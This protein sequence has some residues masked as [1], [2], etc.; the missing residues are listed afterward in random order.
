MSQASY[1][2]FT[3]PDGRLEVGGRSKLKR[4]VDSI[5]LW[6]AEVKLSLR[7]FKGLRF[8]S[9]VLLFLLVII[10]A[11][12]S[13]RI[14]CQEDFSCTCINI[15]DRTDM[16][17]TIT[18]PGFALW[19][20]CF[21]GANVTV[22]PTPTCTPNPNPPRPDDSVVQNGGFECGLAPWIAEDVTNTKHAITSPGDG[23]NFAYQF[24]QIGPVDPA[25]DMHPAAVSQDLRLAANV[26]YRLK[27]R[28]FF[29][30]CTQ[31]E[32][33][34]G[35]MINSQP[36]YTVDA[37][38][39]GAG[40]FTD[41]T[42]EFT[43]PADQTNLRFE[44]LTHENLATVKIDNVE[45]LQNLKL[46][47]FNYFQRV[48]V[49]KHFYSLTLAAEFRCPLDFKA[50]H[51]QLDDLPVGSGGRVYPALEIMYS[52]SVTLWLLLALSLSCIHVDAAREDRTTHPFLS[53]RH[54][55]VL[56]MP[57]YKYPISTSAAHQSLWIPGTMHDPARA[58]ADSIRIM[59]PSPPQI[60]S[61]QSV[62]HPAKKAMAC[63]T[64]QVRI[65]YWAPRTAAPNASYTAGNVS[66]PLVKRGLATVVEDGFTF[67][68]PSVYIIYS[69]IHASA[70][71]IAMTQTYH[72]VGGTHVVTRAYNADELSSVRCV[73][74]IGVGRDQHSVV[75]EPM[76][77]NDLY[78]PIP[79]TESLSRVDRCFAN[80]EDNNV[81]GDWM[82]KPFISLPQDVSELDPTW[83][84]CSGVAIG[85][86]D[87]PRELVPAA[88]WEDSP[89]PSPPVPAPITQSAPDPPKATPGQTV[90]DPITGPTSQPQKD[91]TP[92]TTPQP[93]PPNDPSK[94]P[95]N[96]PYDPPSG[97]SQASPV[98]KEPSKSP[99]AAAPQPQQPSPNPPHVDPPTHLNTDPGQGSG[100]RPSNEDNN[101]AVN[102]SSNNGGNK[103][104]DGRGELNSIS[105][106]LFPSPTTDSG[107]AQQNPGST[108]PEGASNGQQQSSKPGAEAGD[109]S[110]SGQKSTEDTPLRQGG[111]DSQSR[112]NTDPKSP[113]AEGPHSQFTPPD[114]QT[115]QNGGSP[116]NNGGNPN[117]AKHEGTQGTQGTNGPGSDNKP[118][119]AGGSSSKDPETH[120]DSK[121]HPHSQDGN[122][123]SVGYGNPETLQG[124]ADVEK[125]PNTQ[126][127][128]FA[129]ISNQPS[130][131]A[132]GKTIAR[133]PD[134][135]AVIGTATIHPGNAQNVHGTPVSVAPGAIVIGGSSFAFSRSQAAEAPPA[136]PVITRGPGGGLVIGTKTILPGNKDIVNDHEVFVGS[137]NVLVDGKSFAFPR[138][139]P[140]PSAINQVDI[141]GLQVAATSGNAVMIDGLVYKP[142]AVLTTPGHIVSVGSGAVVFDGTTHSLPTM[143]ASSPLFVGGQVVQK[144]PNGDV[145][146]GTETLAPKHP[147]TV[148]GHLVS[149]GTDN[150]IVVDQS[151]Y[152]LPKTTGMV[153]MP[154]D[155]ITAAESPLVIAG[156]TVSKDA[157]GR[158]VIGTSTIAPGTQITMAGH[159]LSA[160]GNGVVVDG[161]TYSLPKTAGIVEAPASPVT[162]PNGLVLTP[163]A[164]AITVSGETISVFSNHNGF[165]I[166]GSTIAF[167]PSTTSLA[168]SVFTVAGQTFTAAPTG[169]AIAGTTIKP[170]DQVLTISGIVVSLGTAGL[171]IGS[172]TIAFTSSDAD[173]TGL[174]GFIMSAFNQDNGKAISTTAGPSGAEPT[175][176]VAGNN[177]TFDSE[178]KGRGKGSLSMSLVLT[179]H[180][181]VGLLTFLI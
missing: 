99:A 11:L 139:T 135:A 137:S 145:I 79:L 168:Q 28:T 125:G 17:K 130:P 149:L 59:P 52:L 71:C 90:P 73:N 20:A 132:E 162:L 10:K 177:G 58:K 153:Q 86:M 169:F 176:A 57:L 49:Q 140:P 181:V 65:V 123:P 15:S 179:I 115:P 16:G 175:P 83:T 37:C 151:T 134:G 131:F 98:H 101:P 84:T 88:G 154:N 35:V 33:F 117:P 40:L 112:G 9:F 94:A 68:S 32:G 119:A 103:Q 56:P 148:A 118:I 152:S 72:T 39:H 174:G 41:N 150:N 66:A 53:L 25:A 178:S 19:A 121:E 74:S 7:L 29:D 13:S 127:T 143:S 104:S 36:V 173:P 67:T 165:V 8:S 51:I 23:S 6:L 172:K 141:G 92:E 124:H 180:L 108:A 69:S 122:V 138:V 75:W 14:T 50:R 89:P 44:F 114:R 18:L 12:D 116:T 46:L 21:L 1:S 64:A 170:G 157:K 5:D 78:Y 34:V 133:A 45:A 147:V 105:S 30:K 54:P 109:P 146:L 27:F 156:S 31:S 48:R 2:T 107:H 100:P 80:R 22:S 61:L 60:L 91:S 76:N 26:P 106:A 47:T 55:P 110:K 126:P 38:D 167:P 42:V 111:I 158:L 166:D 102:Q 62:I 129:F 87:P 95:E 97:P 82:R 4:H 113:S 160:A 144:N 164:L 171:Q 120:G 128:T 136:A 93:H 77:Y 85:A 24:D 163:G 3:P 159:I 63:S 70:S 43:A 96:S 142:G 161:S 155:Q 81:W